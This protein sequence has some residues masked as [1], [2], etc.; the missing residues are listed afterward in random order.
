[1]HHH[2]IVTLIFLG[3]KFKQAYQLDPNAMFTCKDLWIIQE[4][5]SYKKALN[6]ILLLPKYHEM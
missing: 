2:N 1:M 6:I 3:T 5:Q 4:L